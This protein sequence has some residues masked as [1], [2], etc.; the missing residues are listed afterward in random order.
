MTDVLFLH[1]V[2]L[3]GRAAGW[4]GLE[5][6]TAPS[7]PGHGGRLRRPGVTLDEA[8]DEVAASTQ[9]RM[10]VIGASFGGMLALHLALR[11][12]D[13]VASL[14][15]CFTTA[16]VTARTMLERAEQTERR[17][18]AAM[19][20]PTM[21]RWFTPEGLAAEADLPGVRYARERLRA[22][23][24][25]AIADAWRA[26]AGHDVL[27]RLGTLAVP[28]TCIAGL[29]DQSTPLAAMRET[30]DGIP[31]ARLVELDQPHMGFLEQPTEFA[32]AIHAHLDRVRS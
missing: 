25:G 5:G 11:H 2:A 24:A 3:D 32:T 9:G 13:R 14:A 19:V 28:T 8:A 20:Q 21:E 27:D 17:G 29:R 6:V 30:A 15:L 31:G 10:H 4:L 7:F 22:T 1:P 26:I 18:S 16:R 23:P 12:P